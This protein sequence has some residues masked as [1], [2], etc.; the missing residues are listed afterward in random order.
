MLRF[1]LIKNKLKSLALATEPPSEQLLKRKPY[2]RKS[3]V[4][5]RIMVRNIVGQGVYQLAV[6]LLLSLGKITLSSYEPSVIDVIIR[7]QKIILLAWKRFG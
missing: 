6:L 1:I 3:K 2:G 4:I 5:S 7:T